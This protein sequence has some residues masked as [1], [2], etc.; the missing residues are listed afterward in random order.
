MRSSFALVLSCAALSTAA[1][2][3]IIWDTGGPNQVI[4]N[5]NTTY[6]GYTSGNAGAGNEQRWAAVP[7]SVPAAGATI[8]QIDVDFFIPAGQEPTDVTFIVW[9]RTGLAA[10]TAPVTTFTRPIGVPL[11]DP[12]IPAVDNYLNQ[13]TGLS[14]LLAGG[15]Y[16][17]TVYGEG[18]AIAWL[19]GANLQDE[20]LEQGFMWR[21][22]T[23]PAPGFVVYNPAIVQPTPGQDP[24]DRWN[25]SFTIHGEV[26]PAPATLALLGLGALMARRR[27]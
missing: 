16:Y 19:T 22:A 14:M 24:D 27:R 7:F 8:T 6:L 17:L 25:P 12:R 2:G 10:P 26:V 20:S 21:S 3:A 1:Q 4:F 23:F 15:D 13:F 9:N 5:G 18:G 11:D